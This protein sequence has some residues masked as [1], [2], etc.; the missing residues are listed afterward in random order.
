IPQT[1]DLHPLNLSTLLTL[2]RAQSQLLDRGLSLIPRPTKHDW[3]ELQK[4]H[5]PISQTYQTH[6]PF[7]PP[8]QTLL[9]PPPTLTPTSS[10]RISHRPETRILSTYP[11]S[12]EPQMSQLDKQT[13]KL[14]KSDQKALRT[15]HPPADIPDNLLGEERRALKQRTQNPNTVIKPADKG[16]KII[17]LDRQLSDTKYYKPIPQSIQNSTQTSLRT[18][19]TSLYH[20][21]FITA[22]QLDFLFGPENPRPRH[23]YL[24]PKIHKDPTPPGQFPLRFLPEDQ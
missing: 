24:L 23:F 8:I 17:I 14:I 5:T 1:R 22:K 3:E 7:S 18:I 16:S 11:H 6:G 15:Y 21:K 19:I 12:W 10:N 9:P 2:S 20:K 13:I 4:E